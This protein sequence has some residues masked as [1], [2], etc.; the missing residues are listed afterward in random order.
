VQDLAS[1]I[2]LLYKLSNRIRKANREAQNIKAA[3]SFTI[4]N[5][6]GTNVE[7]FLKAQ[8]AHVIQD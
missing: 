4:I 3:V 6:E 7:E 8:F 1:D 2:G 5:D